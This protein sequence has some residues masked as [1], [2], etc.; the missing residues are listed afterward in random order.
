[1]ENIDLTAMDLLKSENFDTRKTINRSSKVISESILNE[2]ENGVTIERLENLKVP[3]FKY[4][5][6]ITIHGVFPEL[7]KDIIAGYKCLIQNQNK[8]IGCKWN[9]VDAEKKGEIRKAIETSKLGLFSASLDSQD[10]RLHRLISVKSQ[11]EVN[12]LS[13]LYKP[14]MEKIKDLFI[15]N[16]SMCLCKHPYFG[17]MFNAEIFIKGIYQKNLLQFIQSITE[18][19]TFDE[20]QKIIDEKEAKRKKELEE[21]KEKDRIESEAKW[22]DANKKLEEWKKT[23]K[24]QIITSIPKKEFTAFYFVK[25]Y[26]TYKKMIIKGYRD[27]YGKM[28]Y[29][30]GIEDKPRYSY[31]KP[32][33][34]LDELNKRLKNNIVSEDKIQI[35]FDKK[36]EIYLYKGGN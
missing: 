16:V 15:G 5:T 23:T 30:K 8:S 10:F 2:I 35:L 9:A 17:V 33:Y 29:Q 32:K 25:E 18:F 31:D 24:L 1:M 22:K 20:Y 34:T 27:N 7:K 13:N 19:N 4:K 6:Q 11:E 12:K 28:V 14:T 26:D 36:I 21:W 3:I